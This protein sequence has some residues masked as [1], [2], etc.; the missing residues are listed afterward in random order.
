MTFGR[1]RD[2]LRIHAHIEEISDP[3]DNGQ[4]VELKLKLDH[5]AEI[6]GECRIRIWTADAA[7]YHL[8]QE[9]CAA[10]SPVVQTS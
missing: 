5:S 3:F 9:L 6:Q 7:H 8:G 1:R 2:D 4:W 10:F